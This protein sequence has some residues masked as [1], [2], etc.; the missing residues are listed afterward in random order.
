M[1]KLLEFIAS[2]TEFDHST[3][4]EIDGKIVWSTPAKVWVFD[5]ETGEGFAREW[6]V[7][8]ATWTPFLCETID[9]RKVPAEPT[10]QQ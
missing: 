8:E 3:I 6:G 4:V 5:A 9:C 7:E 10:T 2:A 1:E